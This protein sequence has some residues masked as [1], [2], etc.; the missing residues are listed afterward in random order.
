MKNQ[1]VNKDFEA[2]EPEE[3]NEQMEQETVEPID[4]DI[5]ANAEEV[6]IDSDFE[7][8]QVGEENAR[9]SQITQS[10]FE[11]LILA[12]NNM[13]PLLESCIKKPVA[14]DDYLSFLKSENPE[15]W[16]YAKFIEI[17]EITFNNLKP[18]KII[19]LRL[20]DIEGVDEV[21]AAFETFKAALKRVNENNFYFPLSKLW[22]LE[23]KLFAQ[24]AD[25]WQT[26]DDYNSR[27]THTKQQNQILEIFENICEKLNE[28]AKL[29]ILRPENGPIELKFL[30]DFFEISKT[31]APTQFVV[32]ALLFSQHRLNPFR[33]KG[34]TLLRKKY[35]P[36]ELL[37]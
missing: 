26:C 16:I 20:L 25:F 31:K 10:I 29:N 33:T 27:F 12:A 2:N 35:L 37:H 30:P 9:Q 23:E 3:V 32:D 34:E 4:S 24:N 36:A 21:L 13:K 17:H 19:E 11:S 7:P 15:S 1:N 8:R 6:T 14:L 18:E 28:L 5:E 22:N